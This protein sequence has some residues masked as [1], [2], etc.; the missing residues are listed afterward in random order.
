MVF[1]INSNPNVC[2]RHVQVSDIGC[3]TYHFNYLCGRKEKTELNSPY[4]QLLF[5]IWHWSKVCIRIMLYQQILSRATPKCGEQL[6]CGEQKFIEDILND[7]WQHH[8]QRQ[9]LGTFAV[10]NFWSFAW[11]LDCNI[12]FWGSFLRPIQWWGQNWYIFRIF[13]I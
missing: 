3:N 1:T 4:A 8:I 5:A 12:C 10:Y 13:E 6:K 7:R 2:S 9:V 11:I